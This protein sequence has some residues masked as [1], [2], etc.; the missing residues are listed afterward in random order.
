MIEERLIKMFANPKYEFLLD[1]DEYK[2]R[3]GIY[4]IYMYNKL[5]TLGTDEDRLALEKEYEK[6]KNN[7]PF[8]FNIL[9]ALVEFGDDYRKACQY[10][11]HNVKM[12]HYDDDRK[13]DE[14]AERD[15]LD[16]KIRENKLNYDMKTYGYDRAK[17]KQDAIVE[18]TRLDMSHNDTNNNF[19][20]NENGLRIMF[21]GHDV[22]TNNVKVLKDETKTITRCDG[23][24]V[25]VNS[26]LFDK[27]HGYYYC[28]IYASDDVDNDGKQRVYQYWS[29]SYADKYINSKR[30]YKDCLGIDRV[31]EKKVLVEKGI[32]TLY[33]ETRDKLYD[34]S[35]F[36]GQNKFDHDLILK[37]Q[38]KNNFS[39]KKSNKKATKVDISKINQAL[40]LEDIGEDLN[41]NIF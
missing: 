33:R 2:Y 26:V 17:A 16:R 41:G 40:G 6:G 27:F 12:A 4:W 24:A 3:P 25:V 7:A 10:F 32:D 8:P 34:T 31:E 13:R 36:I 37:M 1:Y 11:I 5:F 39:A 35:Q 23:L 28:V 30:H 19:V 18:E 22:I 20:L 9:C 29:E 15:E 21:G 38:D 14:I